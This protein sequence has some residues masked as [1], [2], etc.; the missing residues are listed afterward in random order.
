ML[1]KTITIRKRVNW[2]LYNELTNP[3]FMEN[4]DWIELENVKLSKY[5]ENYYRLKYYTHSLIIINYSIILNSNK[6]YVET[7][8]NKKYNIRVLA[9]QC[10]H[11]KLVGVDDEICKRIELD[12]KTIIYIIYIDEK[13]N[14]KV[15]YDITNKSDKILNI[16]TVSFYTLRIYASKYS[17]FKAGSDIAYPGDLVLLEVLKEGI[18]QEMRTILIK[19]PDLFKTFDKLGDPYYIECE[20]KYG[21]TCEV[22]D[23]IVNILPR[24]ITIKKNGRI[25]EAFRVKKIKVLERGRFWMDILGICYD[26]LNNNRIVQLDQDPLFNPQWEGEI[27][28]L[29]L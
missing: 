23:Y 10:T 17:K 8:D 3:N 16:S 11:E 13:C 7:V 14:T 12:I 6:L 9:D 25:D 4:R 29:K 28:C 1:F 15:I 20:G 5:Y 24:F 19:L 2:E 26:R 22:Y 18:N 21:L 27:V